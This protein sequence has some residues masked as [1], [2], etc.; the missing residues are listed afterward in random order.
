MD[1]KPR[2][3]VLRISGTCPDD[4]PF[5]EQFR[6]DD[7]MIQFLAEHP[8][9]Q[10]GKILLHPLLFLRVRGPDRSDRI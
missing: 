10:R 9:L 1:L 5:R 7:I 2:P 3:T 6:V 8:V 4:L